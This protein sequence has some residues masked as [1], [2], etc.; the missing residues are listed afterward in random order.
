MLREGYLRCIPMNFVG[1]LR[2]DGHRLG[3][4][5]RRLGLAGRVVPRVP[6]SIVVLVYP[7]TAVVATGGEHIKCDRTIG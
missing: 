4:K 7:Q 3:V 5:E 6:L 2:L 1:E